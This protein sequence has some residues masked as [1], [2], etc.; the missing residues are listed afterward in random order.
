MI[1]DAV[2]GRSIDELPQQTRKLLTTL[3][4]VRERRKTASSDI[5]KRNSFHPPRSSANS[6]AGARRNCNYHLE[7]LCR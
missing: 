2:L 1:A 6:S 4:L 5:T 7:R 3:R